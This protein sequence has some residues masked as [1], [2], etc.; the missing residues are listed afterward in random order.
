M[1]YY[2]QRLL[3]SLSR[4]ANLRLI[5]PERLQVGSYE[6]AYQGTR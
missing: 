5:F 4:D 1:A 2:A 3:F 6:R